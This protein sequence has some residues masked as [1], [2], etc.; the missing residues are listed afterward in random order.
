[1]AEATVEATVGVTSEEK[2]VEAKVEEDHHIPVRVKVAPE[3]GHHIPVKVAPELLVVEFLLAEVI[4][5]LGRRQ[6]LLRVRRRVLALFH[7]A[8]GANLRFLQDKFSLEDR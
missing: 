4:Q 2:E 1:V 5:A 8:E 7:K 6:F 3:K